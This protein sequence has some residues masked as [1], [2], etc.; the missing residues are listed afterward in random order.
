[1]SQGVYIVVEGPD[2]TGKTTQAQLLVKRLKLDGKSARYV[3]EPG[4]TTMGLELEKIIKNRDLARD[5]QTDFLL[6]TA[7]RVEV[8]NQVINPALQNNETIV[9][10]RNWLSSVAY[11][12][13]ASGLGAATIQKQTAKWLPIEY[14]QPTFTILLYMPKATQHKS[15]LAKRGTSAKDYFESK[16]D[17]FLEKIKTG[18]DKAASLCKPGSYVRVSAE[19]TIE[20]VHA[21]IL[22]TLRQA[23]II[24]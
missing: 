6:F 17:T 16:P 2:G 3:H 5:P 12:G 22:E 20:E 11:Q 1:M 4:E 8:F 19:G 24:L 21:R 13:I 23:S 9:A 7:N 10:D 15:M 18:Y 14:T